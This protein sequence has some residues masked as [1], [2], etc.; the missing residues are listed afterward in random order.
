MYLILN[1]D[2]EEL[3]RDETLGTKTKYWFKRQEEFWLYKEARENTGEDWSEK[4]AAEFASLL[5]IP[6]ATVELSEYSGK[7]GCAC[8]SFLDHQKRDVLIHGNEILAG[9]VLGYD[10]NKK[11]HQSQ[12]TLENIQHAVCSLF[13]DPEI[14]GNILTHLASY[15][16][17]DALI[18]NTDRHHENWGLMLTQTPQG[19]E[20]KILLKL[21]VA[22]TFDHASSLGRE[23]RDEKRS[24]YL[25]QGS[26]EAYIRKGRGAI[27]LSE[28]DKSGAN[29]LRLV[30]FGTNKMSQHFLPSLNI[31]KK[32]RIE[33]LHAIIESVPNARMST[34]SKEFTKAFV[35]YSYE[36][37][38]KLVK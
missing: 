25:K 11:F 24:L 23:L 8:L 38:C 35:S 34:I 27:F 18:G 13:K 16:V 17:L 36:A 37:L 4:I 21:Q 30:E 22:P 32:V 33:E 12:H 26:I 7:R 20:S 19:T 28:S 6:A 10:I 1:L 2:S 15:L 29:P 31:V 5:K 14:N 9:Q 3:V